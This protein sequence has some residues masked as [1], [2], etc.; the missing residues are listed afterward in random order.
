MR[1]VEVQDWTGTSSRVICRLG[2]DEPLTEDQEVTPDVSLLVEWRE[3]MYD[4]IKEQK[5][6]AVEALN[7]AEEQ[8]K[9]DADLLNDVTDVETRALAAA[10][11]HA[12]H[13]AAQAAQAER[14]VAS[15]KRGLAE[16]KKE[17]AKLAKEQG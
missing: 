15:A 17:M 8:A 3:L 1:I 5:D 13:Y 10:E 7:K 2:L 12:A 11:A 4:I 14:H 9:R 16:R 6:K